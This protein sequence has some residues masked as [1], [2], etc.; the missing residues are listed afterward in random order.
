VPGAG[1]EPALPT[2]EEA[3]KAPV[4]TI[5]PPGRVGCARTQGILGM[6]IGQGDVVRSVAMIC[7]FWGA[8][9]HYGCAHRGATESEEIARTLAMG[10]RAMEAGAIEDSLAHFN[11]A[12]GLDPSSRIAYA[13]SAQALAFRAYGGS[14]GWGDYRASRELGLECL[15]L[16]RGFAARVESAGGVLTDS[17]LDRIEAESWAC[18]HWAT[19]SWTRWVLERGADAMALDHEIL[20]TLG[21]LGLELA[22]ADR[23]G[24]ALALRAMTLCI[25]PDGG[26]EAE[27]IFRLALQAD[28]EQRSAQVDLAE[29]VLI[30][31]SRIGEAMDLLASVVS[32]PSS[33]AAEDSAERK[34]AAARAGQLLSQWGGGGQAPAS[35]L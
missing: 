33:L 4:S 8:S 1:V 17:A 20:L 18:L 13:G 9:G 31:Q 22:P 35:T 34:K 15:R 24:E 5:S 23:R 2:G 26:S 7:I 11:T 12:R 29:Y 14:G 27:R 25:L 10:H 21:T 19:W 6:R 28:P 30:P 16:D 3:F 32:G